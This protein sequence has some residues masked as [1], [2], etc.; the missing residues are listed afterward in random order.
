M[1]YEVGIWPQHTSGITKYTSFIRDANL[2]IRLVGKA[3]DLGAA[4]LDTI[5]YATLLSAHGDEARIIDTCA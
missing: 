5:R 2:K 1:K 3:V 4:R